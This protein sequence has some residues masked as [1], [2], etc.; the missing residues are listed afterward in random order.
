M[1]FLGYK[2]SRVKDLGHEV[3]EFMDL[4]INKKAYDI[5]IPLYFTTNITI[6]FL[7]LS[8]N[9]TLEFEIYG[10]LFFASATYVCSY[11]KGM[12][13]ISSNRFSTYR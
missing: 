2:M 4:T 3:L 11:N 10:V 7:F 1:Y 9:Y 5:T 12:I 6:R 8:D 13:L